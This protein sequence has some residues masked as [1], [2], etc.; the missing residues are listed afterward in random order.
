MPEDIQ[1]QSC[2]WGALMGIAASRLVEALLELYMAPDPM[3]NIWHGEH[4]WHTLI[5]PKLIIGT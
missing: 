2:Q 1:G 5:S 3:Q 4:C